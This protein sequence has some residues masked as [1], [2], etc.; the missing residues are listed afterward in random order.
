MLRQLDGQ[1]FNGR[2]HLWNSMPEELPGGII[3]KKLVD[4]EEMCLYRILCGTA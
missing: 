1:Q 3:D 2:I 4:S